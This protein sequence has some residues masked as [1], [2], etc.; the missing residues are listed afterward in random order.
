MTTN[1]S[2]PSC[3]RNALR[4]SA[5][6]V[7]EH[8]LRE[9]GRSAGDEGWWLCKTLECPV[10]YFEPE[11]RVLRVDQM[12]SRPFSKAVGEGRL[13]C[14]CFEHTVADLK[15]DVEQRGR[16]TIRESI[17]AACREGRDDCERKNPQGRCCLGDVGAVLNS[18][19]GADAD[20]LGRPG[21]C[22][23]A[24]GKGTGAT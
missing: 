11:G 17:V 1:P 5:V 15:R 16:S 12:K 14:F 4:V 8:S 24:T 21:C 18:L 23:E 9:L 20:A 7:S 19:A 10:G 2:C 6:T 3:L 22:S 13:V